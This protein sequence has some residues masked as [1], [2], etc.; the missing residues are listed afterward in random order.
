MVLSGWVQDLKKSVANDTD[1]QQLITEL[2]Q[3]PTT[4]PQYQWQ[5]GLLYHQSKLVVGNDP[6]FKQKLLTEHHSSAMG[7][8]S[9]EERTYKRLKEA[10]YWRGMHKDVQTFVKQCDICQQNKNET[11]K[12]P[13]LLQPLPIP[14]RIWSDISMD[15]VEGLPNS[16]GKTVI[17]VVVDRL[18]KAAHFIALS[19]PYTA[20]DVAQA[21][22]DNIYKLHGLPATI[23][24]DRDPIFTSASGKLYFTS[25]ALSC[26]LVLPTT[27]RLMVKLK[28]ST[29]AWKTT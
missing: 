14:T 16:F 15:F 9:G 18:T 19:H 29:D 13:G 23:I 8:H 3:D 7:G 17:M 20:S 21:F 22:L 10:F 27:H 26:A 12:Y 25:K 24:S 28:S 11:T 4:H 5:H 6:A 1:L 2:Q